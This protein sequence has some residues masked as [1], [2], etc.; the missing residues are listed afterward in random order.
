ME[1][2]GH[3]ALCLGGPDHVGGVA[4]SRPALD[5]ETVDGIIRMLMDINA[6]LELLLGEEDGNA[7]EDDS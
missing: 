4:T 5:R 3:L 2:F 7:W 1:S 6:K